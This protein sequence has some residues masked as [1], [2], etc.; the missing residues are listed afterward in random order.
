MKTRTTLIILLALLTAISPVFAGGSKEAKADDGLTHIEMWYNATQ[1]EVG[2]LPN[3]WVGYDILR[4]IG[5][6]HRIGNP[7]SSA[8]RYIRR[9]PVA[10]ALRVE[11]GEEGAVLRFGVYFKAESIL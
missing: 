6:I 8:R 9:R 11:F 7:L 4:E 1:T 10:A 5:K 2:P 3:D